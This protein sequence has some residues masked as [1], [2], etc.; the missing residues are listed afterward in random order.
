MRSGVVVVVAAGNTGYVTLEPEACAT[1]ST[2]FS[3][4]HDD[5]RSGQ[6]RA[7][8]HR[9]IY[10][11]GFAAHLRDLV[12]LLA[13]PDRRRAPQARPG[14][15]RGADHLCGRGQEPTCSSASD[16]RNGIDGA[17]VYVEESGTSMAAPHVSGAIAAFLSVQREFIG[18]P[19]EV[20]RIF[21]DVGDD[22]G[23]RPRLPGW[24][25]GRPYAR[26]AVRLT[27]GKEPTMTEA[28]GG[29]P[30]WRLVFDKDGDI[31]PSP[32]ATLI[33]GIRSTQGSPIW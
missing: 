27:T 23:P 3:A 6:R 21:V 11:P 13:G 25:P 14:R 17:A 32:M 9:R 12:L 18:R 24:R 8:H 10:P 30:L 20:K 33:D 7:G 22:A 5:Q 15:S 1:T 31:D 29:H 28:I 19:E 26:S 4:G 2:K 16:T